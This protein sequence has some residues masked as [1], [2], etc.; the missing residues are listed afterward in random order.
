MWTSLSHPPSSMPHFSVPFELLDLHVCGDPLI[1]L[2]LV[3]E[4]VTFIMNHTAKEDYI[5]IGSPAE[6]MTGKPPDI[7]ML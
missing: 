7:L 4:Y 6:A 5:C 1:T 2:V 3:F